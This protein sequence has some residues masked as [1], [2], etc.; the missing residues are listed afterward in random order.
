MS[1]HGRGR[2]LIV[3]AVF[4]GWQF[5]GMPVGRRHHLVARGRSAI[6]VLVTKV[7]GL[8]C[9]SCSSAGVAA[10]PFRSLMN[11]AWKIMLP[12]WIVIWVPW[13][14]CLRCQHTGRAGSKNKH[15]RLLM[16]A[17]GW[18]VALVA[19]SC[20]RVLAV[21]YVTGRGSMW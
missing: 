6:F 19:W 12:A 9:F 13:R 14:P 10:V 1:A 21:A 2:L 8:I 4:R 18:T 11:M 7:I 17:I 20:G 3:D 5:W 16:V 15:Q